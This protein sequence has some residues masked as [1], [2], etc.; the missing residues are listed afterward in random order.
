MDGETGAIVQGIKEQISGITRRLDRLEGL[1][2]SVHEIA[3]S[4][5]ELATKQGDMEEKVDAMTNSVN[6]LKAKPGDK[7][8]KAMLAIMTAAISAMVTLI[9]KSFVS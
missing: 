9:I 2:N 7:W 5:R 6:E 1:T 4:V 8:D 3:L